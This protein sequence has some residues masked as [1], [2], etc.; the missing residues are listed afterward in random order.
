[1]GS[2]SCTQDTEQLVYQVLE[3]RWYAQP[4]KTY[5]EALAQAA[6]RLT[7]EIVVILDKA[8]FHRANLI[9]DQ[10]VDWEARGLSLWFQPPYAPQCNLIET[11]WKK[12]KGFLLPRRCYDNREQLLDAVLAVLDLLGAKA[13][14][15]S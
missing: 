3:E 13:I 5:L 8:G 12:L 1:M 15:H 4:V 7:K 11:V 9:K 6:Q 2:L 10:Q 14:G